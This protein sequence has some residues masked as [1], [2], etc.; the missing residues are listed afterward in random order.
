MS[1]ISRFG[2][3][4]EK[5]LPGPMTTMSASRIRSSASG[6]ARTSSGSM[7]TCAI[8]SSAWLMATWPCSRR[9]DSRIAPRLSGTL[10]AGSTWPRTAS[11]RFDSRTASSKSPV[12]AVMAAMNRLPKAWS[13][14]PDPGGKRYCIS[15]VISG[16]A[17]ARAAMQLRMSPGGT[18]PSCC[19]SRPDDP[20]S[21]AT[22]TMAV[23]LAE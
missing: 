15:C 12:T 6:L 11:T 5:R 20:P 14:R 21:S 4:L 3:T 8:G 9:P 18:M 17:S 10:V 2:S 16:S 19:R 23:M 1:L 7:V 13:S 22:A